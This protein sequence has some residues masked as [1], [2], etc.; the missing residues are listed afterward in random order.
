MQRESPD[1]GSALRLETPFKRQKVFRCGDLESLTSAARDAM[2]GSRIAQAACGASRAL[3][4][5][6]MDHSKGTR[7]TRASIGQRQGATPTASSRGKFHWYSSGPRTVRSRIHALYTRPKSRSVGID[8]TN[9][10][11]ST[12]VQYPFGRVQGFD[13]GH[14]KCNR[15]SGSRMTPSECAAAKY[16]SSTARAGTAKKLRP[17]HLS[18]ASRQSVDARADRPR[19]IRGDND[20]AFAQ[21][22]RRAGASNRVIRRPGQLLRFHEPFRYKPDATG[23]PYWDVSGRPRR[24]AAPLPA[25]AGAPET[26]VVRTHREQAPKRRDQGG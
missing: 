13:T 22:N 16:F 18:R 11:A 15:L 26:S 24:K 7:A 10:P 6:G 9:T 19:H 23:S 5:S 1:D 3:K 2:V 20:R 25:A 4:R 12:P 8:A 17:D 21:N 14:H